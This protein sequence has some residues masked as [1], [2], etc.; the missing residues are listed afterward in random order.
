MQNEQQI[1]KYFEKEIASEAK[2]ESEAI[3]RE[4]EEIRT[5]A[6]RKIRNAASADAKAKM[7][8]EIS[9]II[10]E[11][12]KEI[13]Q[14]QRKINQDLIKK[15]QE[16]QE[17]IFASCK[18]QLLAFTDGN[19]YQAFIEKGIADLPKDIYNGKLVIHIAVKDKK[20]FEKLADQFEKHVDFTE[21]HQI[22]IGGFIAVN[23]DLGMIVDNSLDHRLE[24]Q[25]EWFYN[26]SGL[27]IQ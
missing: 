17:E 5:E 23:Q 21:D 11:N 4:T 18:T 13:S 12:Q 20:L 16:L 10:L 15:R 9:D 14:M 22:M 25:K 2:K 3:I 1:L 24:E 8:R 7:N 26:H 6:L 27:V 19:D